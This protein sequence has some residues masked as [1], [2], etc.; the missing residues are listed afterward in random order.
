MY[1]KV[2]ENL[3]FHPA[4]LDMVCTF[5]EDKFAEKLRSSPLSDKTMPWRIYDITEHME[6]QLITRLL[7]GVDFAI[8]LVE[9]TYISNCATLLDYVRYVWQDDFMEDLLC[10]LTLP[11]TNTTGPHIFGALDDCIVG[12]CKLNWGNC[13]RIPSDGAANMNV[14]N[15]GVVKIITEAAGNDVVWN[16]CFIHREDWASK[17]ISPDVMAILKE[18]VEFFNAMKGNWLNSR[19]LNRYAQKWEQSTLIY[20]FTLK[21]GGCR[22]AEY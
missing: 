11:T 22:G 6:A 19:L 16:Y 7:S 8:Q 9:S 14:R 15:S 2:A 20:C 18:V 13:K 17:G 21:Y 10:C 5:F 4:S 1:H 3:F 12:K